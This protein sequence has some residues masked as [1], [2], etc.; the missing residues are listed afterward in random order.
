MLNICQVSLKGNIPIILENLKNFNLHYNSNK[1]YIVCPQ[2]DKKIFEN[3][4]KRKNIIII[5]EN[6][7]ISFKRFK[8]ISN[9]YLKKTKYFKI[10]QNRLSWY[11]QQIL[12]ISFMIDFVEKNQ[13]SLIIWDADT[14]L[15]NKLEFNN[16][17]FSNYYGTTSY[18]HKAYYYTNKDILGEL[19]AYYISSLAQFISASPLE[20][21]FLIKKLRK[22]EKRIK[23]TSEWITSIVMHSIAKSHISYNGSLFSEYELIGQ[24]NLLF[25]Y[26]KQI[27]VSGIRD[28]LSGR[29]T[30]F[31]IKIL[32]ILGFKYIAYEH[33]HPNSYSKNMLTRYQPWIKFIHILLKKMSNNIYRGLKHHICFFLKINRTNI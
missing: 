25:N 9:I 21:S 2:K 24:S 27:L 5:C 14:I 15:I 4:L 33:T 28:F 31:Q 17:K 3:R 11:Y 29:L 18:F 10:I 7:L 19:P 6:S 20:I 16:H 12:K 32:K 13:Q 26:K 1:F 23:N 30:K 8:D 22:K